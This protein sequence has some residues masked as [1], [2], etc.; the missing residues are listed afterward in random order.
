MRHSAPGATILL[1]LGCV[2]NPA[3]AVPP[4]DFDAHGFLRT[5]A[6]FSNQDLA[7]VDGRNGGVEAVERRQR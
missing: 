1:A 3:A 5:Y 4:P 7:R 6:G 2:L